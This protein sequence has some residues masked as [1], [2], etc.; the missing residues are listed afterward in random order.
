MCPNIGKLK[1]VAKQE[2]KEKTERSRKLAD[3]KNR[4]SRKI[5]SARTITKDKH[6]NDEQ[7]FQLSVFS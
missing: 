6:H 7:D 1:A 5:R 4:E 3:A 2:A